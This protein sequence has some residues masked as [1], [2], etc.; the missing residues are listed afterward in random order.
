MKD[1]QGYYWDKAKQTWARS[2]AHI[3]YFNA[4]PNVT[5]EQLKTQTGSPGLASDGAVCRLNVRFIC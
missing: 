4:L 3:E 1:G 2:T 5:I